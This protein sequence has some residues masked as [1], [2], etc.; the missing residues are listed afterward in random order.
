MAARN[1]ELVREALGMGPGQPELFWERLHPDVEWDLTEAEGA[2]KKLHGREAVRAFMRSW[3]YGHEVWRVEDED[4][5][6]AGE[7]VVTIFIEG[8][9]AWTLRDE[10]VVHF[11]WFRDADEARRAVGLPG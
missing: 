7:H 9:G 10:Q 1:V 6:D 4:Y 11:K 5:F 8:A 2:G 3:R